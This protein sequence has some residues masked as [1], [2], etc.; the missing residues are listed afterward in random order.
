[1]GP[2]R[3]PAGRGVRRGVA[4]WR[5]V[6][7]WAGRRGGRRRGASGVGLARPAAWAGRRRGP[8]AA[9]AR[10]GGG[11][12]PWFARTALYAGCWYRHLFGSASRRVCLADGGLAVPGDRDCT[13]SGGLHPRWGRFGPWGGQLCTRYGG[14]HP[15]WGSKGHGGPRFPPLRVQTPRSG[16]DT[17]RGGCRLPTVTGANP[18]AGCRHPPR[19][20]LTLSPLQASP[21]Q[22]SRPPQPRR[23]RA[24]S[25]VPPQFSRPRPL[26]PSPRQ[27]S[28]PRASPGDPRVSRRPRAAHATQPARVQPPA[29]GKPS[30]GYKTPGPNLG[31]RPDADPAEAG[32]ANATAEPRVGFGWFAWRRRRDLNPRGD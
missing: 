24:S 7:A 15:W 31:W 20:V 3:G 4:A 13:R 27:F 25:A 2:W 28:R 16:A 22:F 5:G 1:M 32:A 8:A 29:Q 10:A 14:L 12:G 9:G 19:R 30:A 11:S 26:Q 6:V 18:R 21:R 17:P 23:P